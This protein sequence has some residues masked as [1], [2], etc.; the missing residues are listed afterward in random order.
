MQTI[1]FTVQLAIILLSKQGLKYYLEYNFPLAYIS[2][3]N[4]TDTFAYMQNLV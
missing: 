3:Y 2:L 4:V 1:I